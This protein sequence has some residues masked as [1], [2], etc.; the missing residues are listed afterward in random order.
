MPSWYPIVHDYAEL[1]Y[2]VAQVVVVI[3][4]FLQLRRLRAQLKS[5]SQQSVVALSNDQ[6]WRLLDRRS[7]LPPLLPS[8]VGLT[9]IGW[10]WRVLILNHLNLLLL[11]HDE[12]R[13]GFMR[14][15]ELKTWV[16]KA[17][18]W[19]SRLNSDDADPALAE[20]RAV[21]QQLLHP[22]EGFTVEFR[23]WLQEQEILSSRFFPGRPQ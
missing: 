7:E 6:N 15:G 1:G 14:Q 21:L 20:G 2:Y 10:S 12:S 22:A 3:L 8:W 4:I 19:F 23:K 9:E 18:Y 17:R 16:L 11:A 13:R 5:Q